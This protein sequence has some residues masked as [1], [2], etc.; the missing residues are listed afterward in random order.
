MEVWKK[1]KDY[2]CY[3]VSNL[4]NVKRNEKLLAK[5]IFKNGYIYVGLCL[6]GK[7]KKFTVHSLV[8]AAFLKHKTDGTN[9]IVIDHI[10][11]NKIDNRLENLQLISNRE[12]CSKEKKGI[13]SSFVGVRKNK[14]KFESQIRIGNQRKYLGRFYTEIEAYE[15][16]KK[17]L[18]G[19]N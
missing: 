3:Q 1:I 13:T 19:I 17:E 14:G 18:N 4:G 8:A 2:E 6:N 15:A 5:T 10:N 12:N 9:K 11:A 7:A 16:Y